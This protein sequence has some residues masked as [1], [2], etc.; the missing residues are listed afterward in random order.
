MTEATEAAQAPADTTP[1]SLDD[2]LSQVWQ[3]NSP[4][5]ET[6]DIPE[7]TNETTETETDGEAGDVQPVEKP[8]VEAVELPTDLPVDLK[9][10]WASLPEQTRDAI[11]KSHRELS[12]K[13]GEQGR[14]VQGLAPIKDV[15]SE[16]VQTMP[17]LADMH[18]GEA[19]RQI[20]ETAKIA[21]Q[22][23]NDPVNAT[24]Q[25]IQRYGV[26][27]AVRNVLGGANP[28]SQVTPEMMQRMMDEQ[29]T[30]R[31]TERDVTSTVSQFSE[32]RAHWDEVIDD[33]PDFIALASRKNPDASHQERLSAAY[34]MAIR[35]N[36]LKAPE[37][38]ASPEDVVTT[39]PE[40]AEAAARAKSVNVVSRPT[41][42]ARKLTEDEIL[43]KTF[44]SMQAQ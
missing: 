26:A 5:A 37:E 32:G 44:R 42:T 2:A 28:Q 6:P 20:M 29:F 30:Y 7:E 1:P 13:L 41:G 24:L 27:D 38:T 12:K 21:Q 8:E 19:A 35:A 9:E 14:E 40:K 31:M 22:F 17:F 16:A 34:D 43:R 23:H 36:G 10:H 4:E 18:P 33:L 11:A 3:E 15:L 25:V 39:D